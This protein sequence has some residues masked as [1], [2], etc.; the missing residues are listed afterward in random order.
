M[1]KAL[2]VRTMVVV[3]ADLAKSQSQRRCHRGD[4]VWQNLKILDL[5]KRKR[6]KQQQQSQQQ[7]QL[8]HQTIPPVICVFNFAN[9]PHTNHPS[10]PNSLPSSTVSLAN[11][12]GSEACWHGVPPQ[13]CVGGPHL[14]TPVCI[15][16]KSFSHHQFYFSI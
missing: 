1:M 13:G 5:K 10:S 9:F 3:L 15:K 16:L 2:R 4:L 8:D 6:R 7:V 11:S 12:D 14:L